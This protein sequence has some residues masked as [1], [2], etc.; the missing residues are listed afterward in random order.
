MYGL[1]TGRV[2]YISPEMYLY[3]GNALKAIQS[4]IDDPRAALTDSAAAAV[5]TLT[6]FEVRRC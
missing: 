1:I 3:K 4:K 6:N 2:V 5:A